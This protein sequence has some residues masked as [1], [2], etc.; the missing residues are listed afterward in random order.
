M[1][2]CTSRCSAQISP[3]RWRAFW[4]PDRA[5][6][7][8]CRHFRGR[9]S[10]LIGQLFPAPLLATI[11]TA[12]ENTDMPDTIQ[13]HILIVDDDPQIRELLHE[14]FTSNGLRV[15]VTASGKEMTAILVDHAI[16]LVVL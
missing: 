1:R 15:S 7:A 4:I 2:S 12:T 13:P 5:A 3:N 6:E 16:D 10:G 14:Y 8:P 11:V 9:R